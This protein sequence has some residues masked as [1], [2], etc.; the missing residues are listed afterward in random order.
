MPDKPLG[1]PTNG[2]YVRHI[3]LCAD[4][5]EDKCAPRDATNSAWAYLKKRVA[6][7]GLA[8]GDGCIYRSKVNC[9]RVC[10]Q[11]PIAVVYPEGTW[12]HSATED[13]L[14]RILQEHVIGGEP[15]DEYVFARN[16]LSQA[17]SAE[18]DE[19]E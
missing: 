14:E 9:L 11:G 15:V 4:Q 6:E 5:S 7:L 1:L 2:R 19:E 17:T 13:V 12:Y 16:P 10:Q 8:T 3:L 18:R